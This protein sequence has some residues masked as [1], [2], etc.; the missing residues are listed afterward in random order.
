MIIDLKEILGWL[1]AFSIFA[2]IALLFSKGNPL[3]AFAKK[4]AK[5]AYQFIVRHFLYICDFADTTISSSES[6]F[7]FAKKFA[8]KAHRSVNHR[9]GWK[10][11]SFHLRMVV[12]Y[13]KKYKH[14]LLSNSE[15]HI[16]IIVAW[17]HDTIEDCRFTYNDIKKE[18]GEDVAEHVYNLS[19]NKGRTRKDRAN[20]AY[21]EGI[22]NNEIT[23]FVKIC[24][25]LAN[26]EN[27]INEG[28]D[29]AQKY[30]SEHGSFKEELYTKRFES[31]F[32]DME[33]MYESKRIRFN[34]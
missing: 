20:R 12:K 9:Y 4:R 32:A 24:D 11:Y 15:A 7:D 29:M 1:F 21:Y 33:D 25:R 31:M 30:G 8:F 2:I 14:L 6:D 19:N 26:V 18:F 17:L 23:V 16:A 13:V 5:L 3:N 28:S 27:S 34:R 22:R 10:P